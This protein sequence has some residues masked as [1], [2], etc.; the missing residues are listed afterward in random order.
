MLAVDTLMRRKELEFSVYDL[1]HLYTVVRPKKELGTYLF[2]GNHYLRLRNNQM[3]WMRLVI[4]PNKDLYLDDFVWVSRNWELRDGDDV[5]WFFPRHNG[6][7]TS[8][9]NW[10]KVAIKHVNNN[11]EPRDVATLC[12]TRPCTAIPPPRA[13]QSRSG[14]PLLIR[15]REPAQLAQRSSLDDLSQELNEGTAELARELAQREEEDTNSSTTNDKNSEKGHQSCSRN[16]SPTVKLVTGNV[17]DLMPITSST[18]GSK[19]ASGR[20]NFVVYS[21]AA[22]HALAQP[23]LIPDILFSYKKVWSLHRSS[24]AAQQS[25]GISRASQGHWVTCKAHGG[26]Y[27]GFD[28]VVAH[29]GWDDW[30]HANNKNK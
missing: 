18:S 3:P 16:G 14:C 21:P 29:G 28:D 13:K 17:T 2:T 12:G 30:D 15:I 24:I 11:Q 8:F 20:G 25:A 23:K 27:C 7:N 4:V 26:D 6:F 19:R 5:V 9:R 1:I 10:C 22:V